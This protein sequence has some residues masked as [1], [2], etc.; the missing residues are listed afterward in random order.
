MIKQ[1]KK[2]IR[3]ISC[4]LSCQLSPENTVRSQYCGNASFSIWPE[5]NYYLKT[6]VIEKFLLAHQN[7]LSKGFIFVD[8]S[9]PNL[10]CLVDEEWIDFLAKTKMNIVI[11]ADRK[12]MPL[13]NYW[14]SKRNEIQ[15]II[16]ADDDD[17]V[18]QYKIRRLFTGRFIS[19]KK[20]RTL[21]STEFILLNRFISGASIRQII[22]SDN[23]DIKKIYVQKLRLENKIGCSIHKMIS[24]IL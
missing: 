13:A 2:I 12:L 7:R 14:F 11:I 8:F 19:N 23:I 5:G 9:F 20:G 18:V 16:Y 24:Q 15:G 1:S 21:N 22:E 4:E 17:N 6:G 3:C 10:R